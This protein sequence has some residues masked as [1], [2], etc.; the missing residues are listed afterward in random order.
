LL[1]INEVYYLKYKCKAHKRYNCLQSIINQ[2]LCKKD[3]KSAEQQ[4]LGLLD[5]EINE[6]IGG[7]A[8][9]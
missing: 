9:V 5:L 6:N 3:I 7:G 8:K 1:G 4:S 2:K